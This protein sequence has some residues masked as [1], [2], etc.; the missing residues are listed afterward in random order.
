VLLDQ[1]IDQIWYHWH[2]VLAGLFTGGDK[3]LANGDTLNVTYTATL[4]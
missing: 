2:H 4:T 3:I 1:H